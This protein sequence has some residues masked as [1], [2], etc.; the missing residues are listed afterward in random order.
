ML[1]YFTERSTRSTKEIIMKQIALLTIFFATLFASGKT[2]P[3]KDWKQAPPQWHNHYETALEEAKRNNKYLFVLQT[4]DWCS[5]CWRLKKDI[6]DKKEFLELAKKHAVL[7][8]LDIPLRAGK[9]PAAQLQYNRKIQKLLEMGGGYPT[10]K[11]FDTN[12]NL[13]K[14]ISGYK[15]YPNTMYQLYQFFEP[16]LNKFYPSEVEIPLYPGRKD[17]PCARV[18]ITEWGDELDMICNI[19]HPGEDVLLCEKRKVYLKVEYTLPDGITAP[20]TISTSKADMK[21]LSSTPV[22]KSGTYIYEHIFTNGTY[23]L[24]AAI[25]FNGKTHQAK[26]PC[27]IIWRKEDKYRAIVAAKLFKETQIE[28]LGWGLDRKKA[29]KPFNPEEHISVPPDK[30]I[31]FK[32]RYTLPIQVK[33]G[34]IDIRA[35]RSNL[36]GSA[37]IKDTT[38]VATIGM[39][40]LRGTYRQ[41]YVGFPYIHYPFHPAGTTRLG[42]LIELPCNITFE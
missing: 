2:L 8:Y 33:L 13:Q 25:K 10:I 38:D 42:F 1:N 23:Y 5:F 34:R 29:D 39:R 14:T 15:N 12:G 22:S 27:N 16:Q 31:Y 19:F 37:I 6:L 9:M 26:I 36:W 7:F 21:A 11:I 28:I 30:I 35:R 3:G 17:S 24:R 40:S 32:L 4:G 20:L 41:M 18:R